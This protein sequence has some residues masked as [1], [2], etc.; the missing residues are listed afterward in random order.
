MT[1]KRLP[2]GFRL[3]GIDHIAADNKTIL[4]TGLWSE[5][6]DGV[7]GRL[8]LAQGRVLGD[9]KARESLV[10]VELE[11]VAGQVTVGGVFWSSERI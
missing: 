6:V 9:G 7:R 4:A 10:Y 1:A 8:I 5:T 2:D 3:V 11:N